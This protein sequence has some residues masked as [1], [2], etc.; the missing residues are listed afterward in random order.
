MKYLQKWRLLIVIALIVSLSG[1]GTK[2][3]SVSLIQEPLLS[4][5]GQESIKEVLETLLPAGSKYLTAE[6][7]I[8]KQSIIMEDIDG[9]GT[10]EAVILYSDT[11]ENQQVHILVLREIDGTWSKLSDTATG[12]N[13]LDYLKLSDLDHDGMLEII[14][15]L[16]MSDTTTDKQLFIYHLAKDTLVND[17][18]VNNTSDI[19]YE[20]IEIAD[21]DEDNKP[22]ILLLKGEV[23]KSQIGELFRYEKGDVESISSLE[24]DPDGN[25]ENIVSGK[26]GDG[27]LALFIDSGLGAHSML[28]E[29]ITYVDGRLVKVGDK[30]DRVLLKEYPLYSS[31]INN[32]GIIEVGGM[33][34]P[35]G[36][37]EAA[38]A[39]IPFIYTYSDYKSDGSKKTIQQRYVEN[40]QNFYI[41]IPTE[42]Y[43]KITPVKSENSLSLKD[44]EQ[45]EILFEAKW[46][47][48]SN[49]KDTGTILGET[50][51]TYFYT[52]LKEP[53]AIS[54]DN[55]HLLEEGFQ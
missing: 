30:E 28:T 51:D 20:W 39:E 21:Y 44:S 2:K 34:I 43:D 3:E 7:A 14:T 13:T 41:I 18:I 12:Y 48:K 32:D 46:I 42:W 27:K 1:C 25:H 9:D 6:N 52:E 10:K 55:F 4:D 29:I 8:P 38:M 11:K 54:P 23:G 24:L 17:T 49:Y 47:K 50:T 37:E 26:L 19:S 15:G 35:K 31:D 16:K 40:S 45:E 5:K 36:Y 33:Y 22:D 53:M